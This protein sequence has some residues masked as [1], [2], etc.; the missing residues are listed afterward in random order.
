[1]DENFHSAQRI[2]RLT[3]VAGVLEMMSANVAP[4]AS[5]EA[6]LAEALGRVLARDVFA[7]KATPSR[8]IAL[9]DGFALRADVTA[10]ASAYAPIVLPAI[11]RRFDAGE[12]LPPD[13]DA[14]APL[15]FV[16]IANGTARVIAAVTAGDGVLR[17][18]ADAAAETALCKA[19]TRLC[20]S[21]IAALEACGVAKVSVRR[22]RIRVTLASQSNGTAQTYDLIGRACEASGA[23]IV[24]DRIPLATA[25]DRNDADATIAI[26]G[27]GTGRSDTSVQILSKRAISWRTGSVCRRA[28]RQP[29]A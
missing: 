9:R 28:K 7:S 10:D 16:E 21:D 15:D 12:P 6:S 24:L 25:L 3:P 4:V 13:T 23:H 8:Q 26:G 11:P 2:T 27:T 19:G 14:V 18:A 29:L 1:M 22:P 17:E 20:A 5:A